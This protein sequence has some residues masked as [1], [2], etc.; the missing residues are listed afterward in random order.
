MQRA[1]AMCGLSWT[2][3]SKTRSEIIRSEAGTQQPDGAALRTHK[4]RWQLLGSGQERLFA[5]PGRDPSARSRS[6]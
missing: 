4:A 5:P 6:S 1:L 3:R 2:Q